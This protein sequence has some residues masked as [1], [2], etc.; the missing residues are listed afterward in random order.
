MST[1]SHR[2]IYALMLRRRYVLLS[3]TLAN[4]INIVCMGVSPGGIRL[5]SPRRSPLDLQKSS[6][7]EPPASCVFPSLCNFSRLPMVPSIKLS[8]KSSFLYFPRLPP[9]SS[10]KSPSN[11]VFLSFSR[12]SA[13]SRVCWCCFWVAGPCRWLEKFRDCTR[14]TGLTRA[15]FGFVSQD[16]SNRLES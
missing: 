1:N 14:S 16:S 8:H 13:F 3:T 15:V 4:A 12:L 7:D 10:I 11:T 6:K 2:V 5:S 9:F